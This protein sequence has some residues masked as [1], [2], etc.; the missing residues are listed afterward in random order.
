[1]I[2][3]TSVQP[4]AWWKQ[5]PAI[6]QALSAAGQVATAVIIVILTRRLVRGTETY[7]ALTKAAVDLSTR[8]YE[9]DVSPMWHLTLLPAG[10]PDNEVW[11]KVFNLSKNSAIV[12]YLLMRAESEDEH[13]PRKFVLDVAMPGLRE[14]MCNARQYIFQSVEPYVVGGEWTG[15]LEVAVAFT[16]TGSAAQI[17]SPP[18]RF[19]ITIREGRITS[20][21][22]RLPGISVEP[23]RGN[24]Q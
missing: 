2:D 1:M 8:Q 23:Q 9:G 20:A 4:D 10:T 18:F 12:T 14:H 7:A 5:W 3:P 11:L 17:P 19:K 22:S 16:I 21:Q 15:V 24:P 13:E 6:V